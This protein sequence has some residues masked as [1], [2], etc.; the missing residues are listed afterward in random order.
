MPTKPFVLQRSEIDTK[1]WDKCIASSP[2]R[3]IYAFSWYLDAVTDGQW[4]ALVSDDLYTAVM[5]YY[6][7]RK[8]GIIPYIYRPFQC[9]QLGI[10]SKDLDLDQWEK[11]FFEFLTKK[12]PIINLTG[13]AGHR[14]ADRNVHWLIFYNHLTMYQYSACKKWVIMAWKS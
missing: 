4:C 3:R 12:Y 9:Q 6:P 10:F 8:W 5:P 14:F 11:L 2:F 7:K 1:L 13:H